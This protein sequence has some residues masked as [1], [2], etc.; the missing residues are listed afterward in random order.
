VIVGDPPPAD[1]HEQ[2]LVVLAAGAPAVLPE[3]ILRLLNARRA[4]ATQAGP[5][6]EGHY[7]P[8]T[9]LP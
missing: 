7:R 5:W 2:L 4:T 9:R 3:A 1:L 6:V 8:G